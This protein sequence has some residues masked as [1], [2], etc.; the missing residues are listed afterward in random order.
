MHTAYYQTA[1]GEY[2]PDR[3]HERVAFRGPDRRRR[4]ARRVTSHEVEF[5]R[6]GLQDLK[7][8]VGSMYR[9][10]RRSRHL[11]VAVC[12]AVIGVAV[13]FPDWTW[14]NTA[15]PLLSVVLAYLLVYSTRTT[16]YRTRLN[17]RRR[18]IENVL[19]RFG[20]PTAFGIAQQHDRWWHD[21]RRTKMVTLA[22]RG[23]QLALN[24]YDLVLTSIVVCAFFVAAIVAWRLPSDLPF[25]WVLRALTAVAAIIGPA[26]VVVYAIVRQTNDALAEEFLKEQTAWIDANDDD[27]VP[28]VH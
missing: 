3:R 4:D 9:L 2:L 18:A 8:T 5:L 21:V 16:I 25:H 10:T 13:R 7:R 19:E 24:A 12:L 27:V 23:N 1:T 11:A 28:G 15:V 26:S 6:S 14:T 17:Q 22:V 20:F